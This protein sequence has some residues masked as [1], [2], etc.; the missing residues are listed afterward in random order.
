[1]TNVI[2]F[3]VKELT[4]I[5]D[6]SYFE[7]FEDAA[8]LLAVFETLADAVEVIEEGVKI[9]KGD[10]THIGIVEACMGLAVLFRRRTGYDVQQISSDHLEEQR[11]CLLAGEEL[12]SLAIPIRP[13]AL[14]PLPVSAFNHMPDLL[15]AQA[16]F[17]YL[18]RAHEHIQ[19]NAP[20]LVEL[21]LA[22]S[23]SLDAMNA[24]SL[25]ITRLAGV[26]QQETEGDHTKIN[27]PG[28]ETLQ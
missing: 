7:K 22:R 27:A 4:S 19:S 8:L 9:R 21:D 2:D 17:N 16:G 23:H 5:V 28:S 26:A 10:D 24:F 3:P 25:M 15:L 20:Q 18:S 14:R 13:P 12:Q 6:E 1:M 11:R